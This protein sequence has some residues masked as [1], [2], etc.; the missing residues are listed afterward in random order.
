VI[1][2]IGRRF[3]NS[4]GRLATAAVVG[5]IAVGADLSLMRLDPTQAYATWRFLLSISVL[6]A[7]LPLVDWDRSSLGLTMA[8]IQGWWYWCKA[9]LAIGAIISTI[10]LVLVGS[11]HL[12]GWHFP[13]YRLTPT[14]ALH[15]FSRACVKAPLVE[16][17]L[18]RLALCAP[19]AV[20][21]RPVGA[22]LAS[23]VLFGLLHVFYGNV[24]PDNLIAGYFL[25]WAYL[26]SGTLVIPIA[27]HSLG[28]LCVLSMHAA[29]WY[30]DIGPVT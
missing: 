24:G 19:A 9:T 10:I 28:N 17:S 25:A 5:V 21:I 1:T 14:E 29:A 18:Y 16:E 26:K 3:V 11:G 6:I 22:I 23:G 4:R 15:A 30:L 20:L 7:Y 2:P 27:L 8:P 13:D 12:L